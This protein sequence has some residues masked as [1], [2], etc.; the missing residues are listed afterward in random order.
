VCGAYDAEPLF[1]L[2][3]LKT[4]A[5]HGLDDSSGEHPVIPGACVPHTSL[6]SS[7]WL[8][9]FLWFPFAGRREPSKTR[10]A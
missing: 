5:R 4:R 6:N 3:F 10:L 7:Q 1:L 2:L 8:F 9:S